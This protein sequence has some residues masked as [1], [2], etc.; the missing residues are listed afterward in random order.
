MI[1]KQT[2]TSDVCEMLAEIL[3]EKNLKKRSAQKTRQ[4][5]WFH[6]SVYFNKWL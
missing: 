5:R 1:G 2:K 4:S 3:L 6:R